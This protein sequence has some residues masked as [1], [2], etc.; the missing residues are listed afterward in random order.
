MKRKKK[1]SNEHNGTENNHT[2]SRYNSLERTALHPADRDIHRIQWNNQVAACSN[3]DIYGYWIG[4][5]KLGH[6]TSGPEVPRLRYR[7][8]VSPAA[9]YFDGLNSCPTVHMVVDA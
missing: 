3:E 8:T 6:M 4:P 5:E 1:I 2:T 7:E 9:V